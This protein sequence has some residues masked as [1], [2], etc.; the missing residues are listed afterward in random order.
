M[1]KLPSLLG[2]DCD[3]GVQDTEVPNL[4]YFYDGVSAGYQQLVYGS[5]IQMPN[6]GASR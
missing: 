5:Y 1:C 4:G 2:N 6:L 3:D